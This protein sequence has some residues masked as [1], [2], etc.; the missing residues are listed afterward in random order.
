MSVDAAR[1]FKNKVFKTIAFSKL[2]T[3]QSKEASRW[4]VLIITWVAFLLRTA[5][6]RT[7][8]LWRDEVDAIRFSS[9]P[10]P[11]LVS[12]LFQ[13]GH[14]GPLYFLLLRPWRALTGD[15]EFALR[16]PSALAGAV[17]IPLGFVLAR[18]FGFSRRIGLLLGLLLAT[19]PYLVWYGQEAKMYAILLVLISLAFVAYL[20]AITASGVPFRTGLSNPTAVW[21]G[22]FVAATSLSFYFHILSPLML[23]VYSFIGLLHQATL[24]KQWQGWLISMACLTLPYIP[25]A[26]WQMPL[27]LKGFQSGHPFYPAQKVFPLL[28]QLYSG[29]LFQTLSLTGSVL[30]FFLLLCGLFLATKTRKSGYNASTRLA[31][32]SWAVLPPLAV[33]FIS[34]RVQVFE[35]RYLIYV[36]PAF[37]LIVVIGL[38]AIRAYSRWL[39]SLCLG[40]ILV[41]NLVGIWQQQRQPIKADF[42]SAAAYLMEQPRRSPPSIMVQIPYL[43]HTLSYYFQGDYQLLEGLWTNGGKT[44]GAVD[45]EM[46]ALT[47]ELNDLWLVVSE[48]ELWDNRTLTRTWL[49][50]NARLVDQAHFTRVSLYHYQFD[51]NGT[52]TQQVKK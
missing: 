13:V 35:D 10:L 48:E 1:L 43:Q 33:Y 16:Y 39:A 15:S 32:A 27:L 34:L 21:W 31:L 52:E 20:K 47:A 19:S 24:R 22:I 45:A 25:L 40:L 7:Q 2:I 26:L 8:N 6:L 51:A 46:A 30:Y 29:G 18:Q 38:I 37:Y 23:L 49:N 5:N 14:N 4:S 3:L 41:I 17:T 12:G 50:Q 44:E 42:R 28:F 36:T 9:W 11:E